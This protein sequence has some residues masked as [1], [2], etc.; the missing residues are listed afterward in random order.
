MATSLSNGLSY[1][2]DDTNEKLET[3]LPAEA[4]VP[5]VHSVEILKKQSHCLLPEPT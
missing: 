4:K 1:L 2:A 5:S 3:D